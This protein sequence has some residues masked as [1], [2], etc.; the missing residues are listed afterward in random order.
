M[1]TVSFGTAL[2]REHAVRLLTDFGVE[3]TILASKK[4]FFKKQPEQI[5]VKDDD[6]P[7]LRYLLSKYDVAFRAEIK[8]D[9]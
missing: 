4:S 7:R 5:E 1:Y 8:N 6:L 2:E 3:A 9:T